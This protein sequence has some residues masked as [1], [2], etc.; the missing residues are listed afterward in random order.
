[1]PEKNKKLA[2]SLVEASRALPDAKK[3]FLF[4]GFDGQFFNLCQQVKISACFIKRT[5]VYYL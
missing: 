2:D 1:M 3:E 5:W 4:D